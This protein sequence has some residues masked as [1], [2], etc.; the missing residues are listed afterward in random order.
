[1]AAVSDISRARATH[2]RWIWPLRTSAC[3]G[4]S[5]WSRASTG[6]SASAVVGSRSMPSPSF[7]QSVRRPS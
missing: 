2:A 3:T 5:V 4:S 7:I 1:V 6:I